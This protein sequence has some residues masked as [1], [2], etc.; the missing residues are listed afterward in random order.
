MS[1][2]VPQ[3][4]HIYMPDARL[5]VENQHCFWTPKDRNSSELI[6]LK[7][8]SITGLQVRSVEQVRPKE[9]GDNVCIEVPQSQLKSPHSHRQT[10]LAEMSALLKTG[11]SPQP[12][13]HASYQQLCAAAE[14]ACVKTGCDLFHCANS[15]VDHTTAAL[16]YTAGMHMHVHHRAAICTV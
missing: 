6:G 10:S 11:S 15:I 9:F 2:K 14:G 5:A 16:Y 4:V 3:N 7:D 1:P 8:C 12:C 13:L